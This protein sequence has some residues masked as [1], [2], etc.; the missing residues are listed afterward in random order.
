MAMNISVLFHRVDAADPFY[1]L[2]A[3]AKFDLLA[4]VLICNYYFF[5]ISDDALQYFSQKLK[6]VAKN[7]GEAAT[8]TFSTYYTAPD[9]QH[10]LLNGTVV[11][12]VSAG[13]STY[14]NGRHNVTS[15]PRHNGGYNVTVRINK[16]TK[17]D[18]GTYEAS[19]D[20]DL[21][22]SAKN[23]AEFIVTGKPKK[24]LHNKRLSKF[25]I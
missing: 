15:V 6:D 24:L 2:S 12:L 14:L 20:N 4:S 1:D 10:L 22:H 13:S 23:Y 9:L 19:H 21:P 16:V 11:T 5:L 3:F 25:R 7:T 8:I 17:D 18:A